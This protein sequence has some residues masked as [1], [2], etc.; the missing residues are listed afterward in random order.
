[1]HAKG[2]LDTNQQLAEEEEE[3][4]MQKAIDTY[5][6]GYMEEKKKYKG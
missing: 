2:S 6:D 4:G 3:I 5:T 1:M